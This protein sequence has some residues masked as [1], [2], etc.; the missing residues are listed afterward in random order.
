MR[1]TTLTVNPCIDR[2]IVI[3]H[4]E[5]GK[6][7]RI[8]KTILDFSGKGIN[9]ALALAELG[10][11]VTAVCADHED[12]VERDFFASHKNISSVLIPAKGATRV[13][14]KLFEKQTHHM[15]EFNERGTPADDTQVNHFRAALCNLAKSSDLVVLA[16]S[17]SPGFP[18]DFYR[19]IGQMFRQMNVPFILDASKEVLRYGI[20]SSPILI[21]PNAQEYEECFGV[22]PTA[23]EIF[24]RSCK[25]QLEVHGIQYAV[26]S[27]GEEGSILVSPKG[28][29]KAAVPPVE[30]KG[31]QGAGDAMVAGLA[32]ML[33]NDI[34]DEEMLLRC[35]VACATA[36]GELP[37]THMCTLE[38]IRKYLPKVSIKEIV[39]W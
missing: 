4:L 28:A 25:K 35:A 30:V 29:W 33:A 38:G 32:Y 24:C 12:G 9:V 39:R 10:A 23:T 5:H 20:E 27:L 2:T 6:S 11:D 14:I 36:T 34:T 19:E 16:G 7:H 15:T 1:I 37:G 13:N 21:K 17:L 18:S 3:G 22:V 8:K 26:I 31:L